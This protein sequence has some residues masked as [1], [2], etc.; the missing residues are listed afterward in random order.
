MRVGFFCWFF[1]L[2]FLLFSS[3]PGVYGS[4]QARGGIGA[5]AADLHH[6]HSNARS[7]PLLLLTPQLMAM[8]NPDP[9][10]EA[11]D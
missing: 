3:I 2:F 11:R 8:P 5:V 6:S 4:S 7:E 9:L 1:F 10:S